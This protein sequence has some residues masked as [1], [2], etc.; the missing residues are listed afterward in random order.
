[1]S[2]DLKAEVGVRCGCWLIVALFN[3]VAGG[4]SVQYLIEVFA[5]K[6]IPFWWAALI[7]LFVGELSIPVAIVVWLLR[8][9]G[10]L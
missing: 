4:M 6:V 8:L 5:N 2:E 10:V 1:M 3:A 9:F 7:G